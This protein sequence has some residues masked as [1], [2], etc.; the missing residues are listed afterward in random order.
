MISEDAESTPSVLEAV[1]ELLPQSA[2]DAPYVTH[3]AGALAAAIVAR[4]V[5]AIELLPPLA[6]EPSPI[7]DRA[8]EQHGIFVGRMRAAGVAVT[9]LETAAATASGAFVAD[10]AVLV[11]KGAILM[12]PSALARRSEVVD[13]EAALR[14]LGVPIVGAIGAPGLLDGADVAIAGEIAYVG[15]APST[16]RLGAPRSNA[17]GRA[18]F[19]EYARAAG[20][21]VVEVPIANDVLRLRSVFSLVAKDVAVVAPDKV[22]VS[23]FG[24]MTL[25]NVPKGE[26]YAA[27]VLTLAPRR[28]LGNIRFRESIGFMKKAKIAVESIDVWEFGKAGYGPNML[29]LPVKRGA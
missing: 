29:V 16:G 20:L 10:A 18:Q 19:E 4:P 26:Q 11:P 8:L 28:V 21:R 12:R 1:K 7:F 9:V 13:I 15:V 5:A 17:F 23:V 25:V 14:Q 6:S 2:F 27:G 24:D 22:D 3:D